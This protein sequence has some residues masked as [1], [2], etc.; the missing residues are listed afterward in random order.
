MICSPKMAL[1]YFVTRTTRIASPGG[2]FLKNSRH[3][4]SIVQRSLCQRTT[5]TAIHSGTGSVS[6]ILSRNNSSDM[7][8]NHSSGGFQKVKHE[9]LSQS[10]KERRKSYSC[11][12]RFVELKKIPSWPAFFKENSYS[13]STAALPQSL[14][15]KFKDESRYQ[16][17]PEI[18][19]KVS[20][21]YGDITKLEIDAIVNAANNSLLGGGGVDGA[22]HRAAGPSLLNECQ[23]L[24]GCDTGDA[25]IT[26]GYN[27]PARYVIH[28]VGP[29]GER[30]SML[31]QCYR[32]SMQVALEN[33]VKTIAFPCISTGVYGYP[34][35]KAVQLVLPVVRTMLE[36]NKDKFERVIFC[37]FLDI[38]KKLYNR[39]LPII[40]PLN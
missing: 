1:V 22:I 12:D 39:Y 33:N 15:E 8:Y 11:G 26:G 34:N 13:V 5:L 32:R 17:D 38:D 29:I 18:N 30:P 35:E 27:L 40:Y 36:A 4:A 25:K 31:E 3:T 7:S 10:Q 21:F 23:T 24:N 19:E 16:V 28:T 6:Q 37:L 20:V 2:R 14:V 9:K